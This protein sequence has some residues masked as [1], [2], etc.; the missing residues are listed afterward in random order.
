MYQDHDVALVVCVQ[1]LDHIRQ[2][3]E[4]SGVQSEVHELVHV[5]DIVPLDV[6]RTNQHKHNY[7]TRE[8]NQPNCDRQIKKTVCWVDFTWGIP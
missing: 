7:F 6:L 2:C 8:L 4:L 5:V 3:A 1:V